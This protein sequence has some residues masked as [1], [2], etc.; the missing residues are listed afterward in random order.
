MIVIGSVILFFISLQVVFLYFS[1]PIL[2]SYIEKRVVKKT[3]GLYEL[4]F[5]A[6]KVNLIKRSF[7]L[8][9]FQFI[10]D[11]VLYNEMCSKEDYKKTVFELKMDTFQIKNV[12]I[13]SLLRRKRN[14]SVNGIFM[15]SPEITVIAHPKNRNP[16]EKLKKDKKSLPKTYIAIKE[17]ILP[18][19]FEH[20]HSFKVNKIELKNGKFGFLKHKNDE[21]KETFSAS[22]ISIIF[23]NIY[24]DKDNFA[25]ND[26]FTEDIEI[27][28]ADYSLYMKD[29]VHSLKSKNL[30]ISTQQKIIRLNDIKL[31][32]NNL[33]GLDTLNKNIYSVNITEIEFN[34]SDFAEV[35]FDKKLD[36]TSA[37]ILGMNINFYK[38]KKGEKIK[39]EKLHRDSISQKI[40]LQELLKGNIDDIAIDTIFLTSGNLNLFDNIKSIESN[41]SIKNIDLVLFNFEVDSTS[42]S[43]TTKILY[44]DDIYM[45]IAGF[46]MKMKDSIHSLSVEQLLVHTKKDAILA[47]HIVMQPNL[48]KKYFTVS[49]SKGLN[50]ISIPGLKFKEIDIHKYVNF[51]ILEIGNIEISKPQ[52]NIKT[53]GKKQKKEKN[54]DVIKLVS[55]YLDGVYVDKINLDNGYFSYENKTQKKRTTTSGRIDFSLHNFSLDPDN[56]DFTKFFFAN[57]LEILFTDYKFSVDG[58]IHEL[59]VDTLEISTLKS[60][61]TLKGFS[62]KPN[63][64]ENF[65]SIMRSNNKSIKINFTIPELVISE[66]NIHKAIVNNELNI[67][68]IDIFSP[69]LKVTSYP[70]IKAKKVKKNYILE[71]KQNAISELKS[72]KI[73]NGII[74]KVVN[75]GNNDSLNLENKKTAVNNINNFAIETIEK[76]FV[77]VNDISLEDSLYQPID[78]IKNIAIYNIYLISNNR[79]S[80]EEIDSIEYSSKTIISVIKREVEEVKFD[81][82]EI[83]AKIGSFLNIIDID[84]FRVHDGNFAFFQQQN[85]NT[86]EIFENKLSLNLIDFYFNYDSLEQTASRFL[87]SKDI[88]L[89]LKNYKFN[90]KDDVHSIV[91]KDIN[92]ST[93]NSKIE[94]DNIILSPDTSKANYKKISNLMYAY[95]PKSTISDFD[96]IKFYD[97]Q[98]LDIECFKALKPRIFI[99][100][101]GERDSTKLKKELKDLLLPRDIKKISIKKFELD[102]GIIKISKKIGKIEHT[103]LKTEFKISLYNF[104]ID[105]VLNLNK[106]PFFIPVE[107]IDLKLNNLKFKLSD[108]LHILY[109]KNLSV[110]TIGG[111]I[112]LKDIKIS[113]DHLNNKYESLKK[114]GK[115]TLLDIKIPN[116]E[117]EGA[118]LDKIKIDKQLIAE[119]VNIKSPI[120][121]IE[122]LNSLKK[123][124]KNK[125]KFHLDSLDLYKYISKN[126]YKI[127]CSN[128]SADNISINTRTHR[129]AEIDTFDI[130]RLSLNITNLL[131]DST[132]KE[133]KFLYS[134]DITAN[135]QDFSLPVK[136][137][138]SELN[139]GNITLSTSQKKITLDIVA[140][141]PT[142]LK[143]E[144]VEK[145]NKRFIVF[146]KKDDRYL[147]KIKDAT[148]LDITA[149]KIEI[150][151]IDLLELINYNKIIAKFV[152]I[153]GMELLTY[154]DLNFAHDYSAKKSRFLDFILSKNVPYLKIDILTIRNSYIGYEQLSKGAKAPGNIYLTDFN[155]TITNITNDSARIADGLKTKVSATA[156]LMGK[157]TLTAHVT[158]FLNSP[159]KYF[160]ME[161]SLVN[162]DLILLNEFLADA[163]N[164]EVTDGKVDSLY[165]KF[166]GT[167]SVAKGFVKMRYKNVKAYYLKKED[168]NGIRKR[169]KIISKL[170]NALFIRNNN[171]RM[172][173]FVR[174]RIGY[175]HDW[176]YGEVKFWLG[177]L[178]SGMQS[179]ITYEGLNSRKIHRQSRR[180]IKQQKREDK[181]NGNTNKDKNKFNIFLNEF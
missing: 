25:E 160:E 117:I 178:F 32:P 49:K 131:I 62:F 139:V 70:N 53:F 57:N 158:Y 138:V 114:S 74:I 147:E 56:L 52:I 140:L 95:I 19:V 83:F 44:A 68:I 28:I 103:F 65:A 43:D 93:L 75:L 87:F 39:R 119:N 3:N 135:L 126:F 33:K 168:E 111:K 163:M 1:G 67:S 78:S 169:Y 127:A 173:V 179:T 71:A 170:G 16:K 91:I 46:D 88:E 41:T 149:Q 143:E 5:D 156:E 64:K 85:K 121:D 40:D 86:K 30:Y 172:G 136:K 61:I 150:K 51:S 162:A 9:D 89:N 73:L 22:N 128:F 164:V 102:S 13:Y 152:I 12:S 11:T 35:Y 10:P 167:D 130:K 79:L 76:L 72:K 110:A 17:N 180:Q 174:G 90:L 181:K 24:I 26:L 161:G 38:Q 100:Q 23:N 144:F 146:D 116:I 55:S 154:K 107:N 165:F 137:L 20:F 29:G 118:D 159:N 145:L 48:D 77:K 129:N 175:F 45:N 151:E 82:K 104:A 98:T 108:S 15:V 166:Q 36:L 94:L 27:K 123:T 155:G 113:H 8:T 54:S 6:I 124:K 134:D 50:N 112:L 58:D 21:N 18:Q 115:S 60:A 120:I 148:A 153:N 109:I 97:K 37:K 7:V 42:I 2:K 81:K 63:I 133:T 14:L 101:Q 4:K 31:S 84:T 34:N 157:G 69:N 106:K 92:I 125:P 59:N 171:P 66:N 141:K 142:C 80:N 177:A 96:L 132:A 176:S 105:S 47:R 122:I 99:V